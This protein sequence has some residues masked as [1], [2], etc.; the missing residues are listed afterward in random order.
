MLWSV[1]ELTHKIG[2]ERERARGR[3]EEKKERLVENTDTYKKGERHTRA[4]ER[5]SLY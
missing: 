4:R 3:E 5:L 2:M 1:A